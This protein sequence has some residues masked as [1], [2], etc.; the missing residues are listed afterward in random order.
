MTLERIRNTIE[1]TLCEVLPPG[2]ELDAL[3]EITDEGALKRVEL[4][5]M[6]WEMDYED[7]ILAAGCS[8]ATPGGKEN[9]V[10]QEG[11]LPQYICEVA[12][13][14]MEKRGKD[15]SNAIQIA[16]GVIKRWAKGV[17]DVNADTRAKAVAAV[18]QWEKMKA[19]AHARPNKS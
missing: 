16:V 19:S 10:E 4:S 9:W 17:G 5:L 15:K 12:R 2:D 1:P 6:L 7:V 18:A 11:G 13:S 3:L 8:L 14:I